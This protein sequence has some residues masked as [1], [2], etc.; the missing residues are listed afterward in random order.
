T[1]ATARLRRRSQSTPAIALIASVDAAPVAAP[2]AMSAIAG[3]DW[4]RRRSLA[5]AAVSGMVTAAP[6]ARQEAASELGVPVVTMDELATEKVVCDLFPV[7]HRL[8][9][10]G[11]VA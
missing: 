11:A 1:A 9:A 5:G 6:L 7:L 10:D 8:P 4:L 3:V 2:D